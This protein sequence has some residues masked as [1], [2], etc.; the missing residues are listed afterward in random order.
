MEKIKKGENKNEETEEAKKKNV[1][2]YKIHNN[3]KHN[4]FRIFNF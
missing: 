1:I 3:I 4:S 2:R